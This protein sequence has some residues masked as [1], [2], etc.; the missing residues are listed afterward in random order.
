M[1]ETQ[2]PDVGIEKFFANPNLW[3]LLLEIIA[4]LDDVS[5]RNCKRVSRL[6]R[7]TFDSEYMLA[8]IPKRQ[9]KIADEVEQWQS[10]YAFHWGL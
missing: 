7:H 6:W 8:R 3:P 1:K 2:E 9:R 10:N 4:K 5:I